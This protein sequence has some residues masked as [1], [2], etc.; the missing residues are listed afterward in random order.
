MRRDAPLEDWPLDNV[1]ISFRAVEI[2]KRSGVRTVGHL[3]ALGRAS[4]RNILRI[5][6]VGPKT[7]SEIRSAVDDLEAHG[8]ERLQEWKRLLNEETPER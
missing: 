4:D 5:A 8:A 3:L 7:L 6:R 1:A 2:L